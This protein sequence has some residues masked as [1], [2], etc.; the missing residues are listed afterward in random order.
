MNFFNNYGFTLFFF[1]F[2]GVLGLTVP[3]HCLGPCADTS[4]IL[5]SVR[6]QF[7][8]FLT[9]ARMCHIVRT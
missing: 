2:W 6:V 7:Y 5:K 3:E 8:V 1:I 9:T 4:A